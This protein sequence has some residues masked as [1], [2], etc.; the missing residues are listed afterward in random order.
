[1]E[2]NHIY[3]VGFLVLFFF[4]KINSIPCNNVP[5]T[6]RGG[7]EVEEQRSRMSNTE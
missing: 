1:M 4:L 2:W 6:W 5:E 7:Q 3:F